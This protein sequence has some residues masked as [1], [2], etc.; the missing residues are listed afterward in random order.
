MERAV[1]CGV[2]HRP[3]FQTVG[4][5][6]GGY[7]SNQMGN[8]F[9]SAMVRTENRQAS[10]AP[11]PDVLAAY[12]DYPYKIFVDR[13]G[14][15]RVC[16]AGPIRYPAREAAIDTE[17][18]LEEFRLPKN[19]PFM[20]LA[21]PGMKV[22]AYP[23]LEGA[24]RL[25]SRHPDL[26][27]LVKFHYHLPLHGT[28]R[29]L[30]DRANA[31]QRYRIFDDELDQLMSVS[32]LMMTGGSS[33]IFEAMALNCMPVIYRPIGEMPSNILLDVPEAAFFWSTFDELEHA[34][35]ACLETSGEYAQ[36]RRSWPRALA[37]Q[38]STFDDSPN[39]R[40]YK[41]IYNGRL[42]QRIK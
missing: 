19:A 18:F 23:A 1:W 42:N 34:V 20:F 22:E 3:D 17:R 5:Q 30:A 14:S 8:I 2:K 38:M 35:G 24:V 28:L 12:G 15:E 39:D 4:L 41:F 32:S 27:L 16:H 31:G 10:G 13:L 26:F 29:R 9:P 36:R 40:L 33:T 7:C 6:A 25:L 37:A 11:L 21:M